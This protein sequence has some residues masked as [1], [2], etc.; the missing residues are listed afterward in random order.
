MRGAGNPDARP[1]RLLKRHRNVMRLQS[2]AASNGEEHFPFICL[3][4]TPPN[5]TITFAQEEQGGDTA[6][7][8]RS[9]HSTTPSVSWRSTTASSFR[10]LRE[11]N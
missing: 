4:E 9:P 2:S 3:P 11:A 10:P 6:K 7:G 1:I 5:T 8:G